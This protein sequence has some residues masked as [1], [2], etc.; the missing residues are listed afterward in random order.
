MLPHNLILIDN[1]NENMPL[2]DIYFTSINAVSQLSMR[3]ACL[4][5][6]GEHSINI[7]VTNCIFRLVANK[8]D[9]LCVFDTICSD[10][11][12]CAF[13]AYT[14]KTKMNVVLLSGNEQ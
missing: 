3:L 12:L 9:C 8:Y 10:M 2:Y 6:R 14:C 13:R 1:G 11:P 5:I 4:S 7:L